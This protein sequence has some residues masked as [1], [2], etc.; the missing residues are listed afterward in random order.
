MKKLTLNMLALVLTI[1][2]ATVASPRM[3]EV[4]YISDSIAETDGSY[5]RLLGGSIW[6]LSLPA[7][8]LYGDDIFIVFQD[9]DLYGNQG[10]M[11]AVVYINGDEII[12]K[13]VSGYYLTQTG[14]LTTVVKEHGGGAV[15][16][17][18]DGTLLTVP[19]YDRY[20]TGW[21]LPPYKVLLTGNKE[22]LWNLE[23]GKRIWVNAIPRE[24]SSSSDFI[25]SQ[26]DGDSE[27][28]EGETVITLMNGQIWQQ[29]EYYYHYHY[30]YMPK[31]LIYKS[32]SGYKMKVDGIDKAVAVTRLK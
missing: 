16:E 20:D 7:Y 19:Q 2:T 13:N 1:F 21:W 22:Y 15:L 30:S 18:D 31:V 4:E 5:V 32:G 14:Y 3:Q 26:I 29:V 9:S 23:K 8:A 27:G 25:E 10:L 6:H 11:T 28:W 24:T 12:A 17:L